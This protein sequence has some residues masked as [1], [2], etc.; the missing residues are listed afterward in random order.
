MD[1]DSCDGNFGGCDDE[2]YGYD[3]ED[4]GYNEECVAS[5]EDCEYDYAL[6]AK[7]LPQILPV[8]GLCAGIRSW[9]W[10][11]HLFHSTLSRIF[12]QLWLAS[13]FD[14]E[15]DYRHG[16]STSIDEPFLPWSIH[17][18]CV[19]DSSVPFDFVLHLRWKMDQ[20]IKKMSMKK[21]LMTISLQDKE[22]QKSPLR[23]LQDK[24]Y[25]FLDYDVPAMFDE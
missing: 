12:V 6:Y 2:E 24:K 4:Y 10:F 25:L 21:I 15:H 16:S 7:S 14:I 13:I 5:K 19:S 1:S 23:K 3:D 20:A 11:K 8:V 17:F 9:T 18:N 22:R